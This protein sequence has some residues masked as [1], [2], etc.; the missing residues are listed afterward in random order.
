MLLSRLLD[1]VCLVLYKAEAKTVAG[2]NV[3]F[4]VGARICV[5]V[6]RDGELRCGMYLYNWDVDLP[7]S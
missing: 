4:C 2:F 5:R 1:D 6:E 7:G 3:P